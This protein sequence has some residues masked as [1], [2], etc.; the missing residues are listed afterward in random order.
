VEG[1]LYQKNGIEVYIDEDN[2]LCFF[3]GET[4]T[5]VDDTPKNRKQVLKWAEEIANKR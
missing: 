1:M 4:L 2:I 5:G 3:D